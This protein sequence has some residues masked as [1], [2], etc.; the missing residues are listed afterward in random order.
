M[1]AVTCNTRAQP[2][3]AHAPS[4]SAAGTEP[5]T[6]TGVD[7]S[8]PAKYAGFSSA[9]KEGVFIGPDYTPD[10]EKLVRFAIG[11]MRQARVAVQPTT[12]RALQS[13]ASNSCT[14]PRDA[15]DYACP[16]ASCSDS[17]GL[18]QARRCRFIGFT[19]IGSRRHSCTSTL[20][21]SACTDLCIHASL[22]AGA[23]PVR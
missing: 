8:V 1:G 2:V 18:L 23:R 14:T 16:T 3:A 19:H 5:F 11:A 20:S 17:T 9:A 22:A 12:T 15:L 13:A 10:L 4:E 21:S 7:C 6:E